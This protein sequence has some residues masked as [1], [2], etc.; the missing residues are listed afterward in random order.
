MFWCEEVEQIEY[1]IFQLVAQSKLDLANEKK[2][3]ITLF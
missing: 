3:M 1:Q 2:Y